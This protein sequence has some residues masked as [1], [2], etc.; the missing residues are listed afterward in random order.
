M[1]RRGP[2]PPFPFP[3]R[4]QQVAAIQ[5]AF[6]ENYWV[7]SLAINEVEGVEEEIFEV[8]N[9]WLDRLTGTVE[10]MGCKRKSTVALS[11]ETLTYLEQ[12]E[13]AMAAQAGAAPLKKPKTARQLK[14]SARKRPNP[15]RDH[16]PAPS[17]S[18][19]E[20]ESTSGASTHNDVQ[21]SIV[22]NDV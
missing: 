22:R 21:H 6:K 15:A 4:W 8:N 14:K 1:A 12:R 13:E 17:S 10:R 20:P 2:P 19:S 16:P 7:P 18:E 9:E 11:A 5:S 3:Q